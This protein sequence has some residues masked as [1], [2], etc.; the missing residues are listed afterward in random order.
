MLGVAR[1]VNSS[2]SR[3]LIG[4]NIHKEQTIQKIFM[5][6]LNVGIR[7]QYRLKKVY[8]SVITVNIDLKECYNSKSIYTTFNF[9][10]FTYTRLLGVYT[11]AVQ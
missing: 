8:K 6:V 3:Y 1:S 11:Q 4:N 7:K 5:S 9:M 2:S 10:W